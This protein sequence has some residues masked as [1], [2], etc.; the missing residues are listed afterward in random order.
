GYGFI[1]N[2]HTAMPPAGWREV[3]AA[4]L[5]AKWELPLP[6]VVL[7]GI[8]SGYFAISEA[9]AVTALYVL[10]VEMLVLREIE[11]RELPRIVRE[12]VVLVGAILTI[13]CMVPASSHYLIHTVDPTPRFRLTSAYS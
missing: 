5:N 1:R 13:L 9:A 7:G 10:V 2:R 11:W 12:A 3:V 8:Y 4:V 6:V